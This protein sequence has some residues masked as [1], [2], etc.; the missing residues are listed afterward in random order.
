MKKKDKYTNK[1][2]DNWEEGVAKS[3]SDK[4]I[5][6]PRKITAH[7]DWVID[8]G[9]G[10]T[11]DQLEEAFVMLEKGLKARKVALHFGFHRK[12]VRPVLK[13]KRFGY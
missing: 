2:E 5:P 12:H 1:D 10:L 7:P 6:R 9:V 13:N 3:I 4:V 11:E 8:K